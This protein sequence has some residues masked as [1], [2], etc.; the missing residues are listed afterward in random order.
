MGSSVSRSRRATTRRQKNSSAPQ[1]RTRSSRPY[2]PKGSNRFAL[3][4][5]RPFE[6]PFPFDTSPNALKL[7]LMY[8]P[9]GLA[10]RL[11]LRKYFE[12]WI[13]ARGQSYYATGR[14]QECAAAPVTGD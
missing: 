11:A 12:G 7:E 6:A 5:L 9:D 10:I 2:C 1:F 14:V 3:S 8:V 4:R 13:Y